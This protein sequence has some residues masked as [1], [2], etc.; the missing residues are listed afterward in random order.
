MKISLNNISFR[1]RNPEIRFA[2]DI[3]RRV[4]TAYPTISPTKIDGMAEG[5]SEFSYLMGK[6]CGKIGAFRNNEK[7]KGE[8]EKGFRQILLFI[9]GLKNEKVANCKELAEASMIAAKLN[10]IEDC[11]KA[12]LTNKDG[13]DLDHGIL[14]VKNGEKPY[15]IDAWLGF[16]DYVD[17]AKQRYANEFRHHFDLR[18]N[19]SAKDIKFDLNDYSKFEDIF[20]E[21]ISQASLKRLKKK[22]PKLVIKRRV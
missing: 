11:T 21:E 4:N 20:K 12:C 16:A 9:Q 19:E 14:Y 18:P 6:L 22:L 17:A 15:I 3:A 10:G 8:G 5:K 13:W 2:D 1:A 7:Y